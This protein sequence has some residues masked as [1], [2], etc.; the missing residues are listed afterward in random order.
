M[1]SPVRSLK[2]VRN[3]MTGIILCLMGDAVGAPPEELQPKEVNSTNGGKIERKTQRPADRQG[4]KV[5]V[6]KLRGLVLLGSMEQ[7]ESKAEATQIRIENVKFLKEKKLPKCLHQALGK[8]VT[9]SFLNELASDIVLFYRQHDRPVVDV[10]LPEQDISNGVVQFVIVE[11][12][13]DKIRTRGVAWSAEED[14]KKEIRIEKGEIIRARTLTEDVQWLNRSPFRNIDVLL[15]PG[16]KEGYTDIILRVRESRRPWRVY[17]GYE[18]SGNNLTGVERYMTGLNWGNILTDGD[19]L[20]YQFTTSRDFDDLKA[21]AASYVAPLPWRHVLTLYGSYA[22]TDARTGGVEVGG[23]SHQLGIQYGIRLPSPDFLDMR[24]EFFGG[25]EWKQSDSD[26]EFGQIRITDT[27]TDIGQFLL[28]YRTRIPD[29]L[30]NTRG[31]VTVYYSP[32]GMFDRA[33][34][35]DYEAVRQGAGAEYI[36]TRLELERTTYLPEEFSLYNEL[37]AQWSDK[38]L[39]PSEQLGFGGYYSIRGF[40]SRALVDTDEGIYLRSELHSPPFGIARYLTESFDDELV[41]LVFLDY[42][43][44]YRNSPLPGQEEQVTMA[45]FG[46]GFRYRLQDNVDLRFDYGIQWIDGSIPDQSSRV[47]V[48]LVVSF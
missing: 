47:H 37:A 13:L 48:G 16:K 15:A 35:G 26:V 11:G 19:V 14:L 3:V 30:G 28:G 33:A 1:K 43:I 40:D 34:D 29:S 7:V 32:G 41:L 46:P 6:D 20:N 27:T 9:L 24:H 21:H 31:E 10:V 44:A 36:Y 22:D 45:S 39:L 5:I 25:F 38:N 4:D 2:G 23:E 42:G 12:K 18:D 8:P 17:A